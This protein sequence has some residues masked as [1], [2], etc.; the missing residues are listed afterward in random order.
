ML[1]DSSP[2][3]NHGA[4]YGAQRIDA[5]V[6]LY[7][8]DIEPS[9]TRY[10]YRAVAKGLPDYALVFNGTS[11]YATTGIDTLALQDL[12]DI[13]IDFIAYDF[14]SLDGIGNRLI[15]ALR[16]N[17][18]YTRWAIGAQDGKIA[19]LCRLVD[20][21]EN[22]QQTGSVLQKNTLYNVRVVYDGSLTKIYLNGV[23][24]IEINGRIVSDSY[25]K[26]ALGILPPET[27]ELKRYWFGEIR[28]VSFWN[29]I[30]IDDEVAINNSI[31]VGNEPGLVAYY[32]IVEGEGDILV[33]HT[34]NQN[35]GTIYG[36][37]WEQL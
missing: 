27:G 29:R 28:K 1:V 24:D 10:Y 13:S 5:D 19:F 7:S 36:A 6:P 32:R 21:P 37:T 16:Q 8:T 15:T 22:L 33:D 9:G 34:M 2:S 11:S 12:F 23:L 31:I 18:A 25:G 30:R 20:S 14:N 4:I 3:Y 17:G 35:H 26:I